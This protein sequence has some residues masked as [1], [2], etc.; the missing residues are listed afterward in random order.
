NLKIE[1]SEAVVPGVSNYQDLYVS[2][3]GLVLGVA[4]RDVFFVFDPQSRKVIK[5]VNLKKTFG[6]KIPFIQG[7]RSFVGGP[8]DH[9]YLLLRSGILSIDP[10]TYKLNLLAKSPEPIMGGGAFLG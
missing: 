3:G 8:D 9:I 6:S 5:Q 4:E 1:W 2:S 10:K 7:Q